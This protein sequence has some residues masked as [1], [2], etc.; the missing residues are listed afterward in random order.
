MYRLQMLLPGCEFLEVLCAVAR[1]ILHSHRVHQAQS[2]PKFWD[3]RMHQLN[4][5]SH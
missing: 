4:M 3:R 1:A 2:R 5:R